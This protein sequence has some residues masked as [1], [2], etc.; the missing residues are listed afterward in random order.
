MSVKTDPK[1]QRK[2]LIVDHDFQ[3]KFIF[4]FWAF[5][6]CGTV[7]S[8]FIIYLMCGRSMTT[9]F[10]D[11]RL[12]IMSTADFILPSFLLSSLV[13]VLVVGTATAFFALFVSHRI[14]GPAY[15]MVQDLSK[16]TSGDLRQDFH[17]RTK[18]ELK[19]LAQ[20]L[21]DMGKKIR[22]DVA[23]LKNEVDHLD[24]IEKGLPP[25][26]VE[27]LRSMKKILGQYRV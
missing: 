5:V 12:K 22:A 14:A 9:V 24:K 19:S 7:L 8:G 21:S 18:D 13:V 2:I 27:R 3:K 4:Q 16:F 15:R 11:S 6:A 10:Q 20:G 23:V 17:L 26:A 25:Q 1:I